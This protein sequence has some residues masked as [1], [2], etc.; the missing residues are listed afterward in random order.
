MVKFEVR[1]LFENTDDPKYQVYDNEAQEELC[2]CSQEYNAI[3][4]CGM[5]NTVTDLLS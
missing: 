3:Y 2:V 5:S 4:I 1:V